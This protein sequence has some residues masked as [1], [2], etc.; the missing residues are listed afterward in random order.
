MYISMN[1]Y[2]KQALLSEFAHMYHIPAGGGRRALLQ[3]AGP[4]GQHVLPICIYSDR[5]MHIYANI[6]ANIHMKIYIHKHI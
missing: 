1:E 6:P 3:L 4:A 5:F 2:N